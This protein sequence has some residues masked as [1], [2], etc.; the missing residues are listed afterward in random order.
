MMRYVGQYFTLVLSSTVQ[1]SLDKITPV[2]L[3][4]IEQ[5]DFRQVSTL[6]VAGSAQVDESSGRPTRVILLHL[7]IHLSLGKFQ[8]SGD[9]FGLLI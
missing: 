7:K 1:A 4:P 2:G 5:A 8:F 3:N 9:F 6:M